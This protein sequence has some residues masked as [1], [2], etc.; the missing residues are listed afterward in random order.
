MCVPRKVLQPK[1]VDNYVVSAIHIETWKYIAEFTSRTSETLTDAILCMS[2]ME[3]CR[4]APVE[5]PELSTAK[6]RAEVLRYVAANT[7]REQQ[8]T[9]TDVATLA[10]TKKTGLE[11][12]A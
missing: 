7:S 8:S 12:H 4:M 5:Y 2:V 6:M 3:P 10:A 11:K 1:R 9:P